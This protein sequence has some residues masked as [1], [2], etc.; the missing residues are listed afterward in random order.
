MIDTLLQIVA[1]HHCYDC[2]VTGTLLCNNCK[3]DI[4]S[5]TFSGCIS[6]RTLSAV[7]NVCS[8]C[9]RR[10][11]YSKAWVVGERSDVLRRLLDD[12]KFERRIAA[13]KV[14]AELLD[15]ILPVLPPETIVTYIPTSTTHIRQRGYDHAQLI[16][17]RF[18]KRRG[19][20]CRAT[21]LRN[22]HSVQHGS[23]RAERIKQADAAY[24]LKPIEEDVPFLMIDD[25]FTT[26]ATV[27]A[28]SRLLIDA[29]ASEV[30]LGIIARQPLDARGKV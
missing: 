4:V 21:L 5:E 30:W 19:L 17:K 27:T 3:Y 26:G 25:I 1:P 10:F 22:G 7:D 28:A 16:A 15:S 9:Q 18:A 12:Y 23:S 6:C 24:T 8:V 11:P 20:V 13:A 2:A 14:C 29:G